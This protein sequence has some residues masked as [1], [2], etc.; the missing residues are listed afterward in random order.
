MIDVDLASN[1][2]WEEILNNL[3]LFKTIA[4]IDT[5]DIL[6]KEMDSLEKWEAFY[7]TYLKLSAFDIRIDNTKYKDG[8]I[9]IRRWVCSNEG[10]RSE[11]FLNLPNQKKRP[12]EITRTG[13]QATIRLL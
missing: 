7:K 1:P 13:C 10:F 3:Q 4:E 6:S 9:S 8:V 2:Q 5:R 12:K 11:N